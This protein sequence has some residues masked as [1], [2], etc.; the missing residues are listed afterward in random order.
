[1]VS[2]FYIE[3]ITGMY[4]ACSLLLSAINQ[5]NCSCFESAHSCLR[6]YRKFYNDKILNQLKCQKFLYADL[7]FPEDS[8][9]VV[10][11]T[12]SDSSDKDFQECLKS[13]SDQIAHPSEIIILFNGLRFCMMN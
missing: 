6:K 11:V 13:I 3:E 4:E 9:S 5:Y 10:I 1:M 12:N 8:I 7:E 2:I